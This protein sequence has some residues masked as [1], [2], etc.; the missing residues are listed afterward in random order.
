[1]TAPGEGIGEGHTQSSRK[2]SISPHSHRQ[3]VAMIREEA[4]GQSTVPFTLPNS[5]IHTL[6]HTYIGV[7]WQRE[8]HVALT[9]QHMTRDTGSTS[10]M[11]ILFNSDEHYLGD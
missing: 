5:H 10:D 1:M 3:T 2:P 8:R 7:V 4:A 11:G 6:K 9:R